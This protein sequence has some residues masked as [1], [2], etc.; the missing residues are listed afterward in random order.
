[1]RVEASQAF[2]EEPPTEALGG[3]LVAIVKARHVRPQ[4]VRSMSATAKTE[5]LA[6]ILDP[7]EPVTAALLVGLHL[8][9]RRELLVAFLDAVHIPHENGLIQEE[10]S[11][12]PVPEEALKGGIK[13]L[14]GFPAGQAGVYLNV[15]W[16]Q[17]PDRWGRLPDLA[18]AL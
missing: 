4:V 3:A 16:L 2:W 6:T 12:E 13:A 10:E 7:G 15:L 9:R 8:R 5:A 11:G 18:A 1:V 17:D 14:E